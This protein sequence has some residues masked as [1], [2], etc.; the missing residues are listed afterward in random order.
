[1]ALGHLHKYQFLYRDLKTENILIEDDG[2]LSLTDFGLAKHC[3][4]GEVTNSFC[5]T[6]HYLAPE[7]I[8]GN[9]YSNKIDWWALGIVTYEMMIGIPP[10]YTGR[11]NPAK[12][13]EL[14]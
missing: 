1:M 5:G 13:Y 11:T 3:E 12:T 9:G 10:F 6:S 4:K 2:Y 8:K 14:I 7:M